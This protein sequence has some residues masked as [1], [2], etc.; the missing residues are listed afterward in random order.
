[1]LAPTRISLLHMPPAIPR[2][3]APSC[4]SARPMPPRPSGSRATFRRA[5]ALRTRSSC[6][7]SRADVALRCRLVDSR[8][9]GGSA[10]GDPL[11]P[12][13]ALAWCAC[14]CACLDPETACRMPSEG[15]RKARSNAGGL[16]TGAPGLSSKAS[17]G[18]PPRSARLGTFDSNRKVT[19][20]ASIYR[21]PTH[22]RANMAPNTG[23]PFAV[24]TMPSRA[25]E[26]RRTESSD[27]G[28]NSQRGHVCN[29]FASGHLTICD[30]Y[31]VTF[32][33]IRIWTKENSCQPRSTG[34][35]TLTTSPT[36]AR[37]TRATRTGQARD[38]VE[39]TLH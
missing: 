26:K 4:S 13:L 35:A 3:G 19:A 15:A 16:V 5:C 23:H 27:E 28:V 18:P 11:L 8:W 6:P 24:S 32:R 12:A 25:C 29:G 10:A 30:K 34:T 17:C 14:N 36:K 9:G 39:S 22:C 1:M 38:H 20:L 7:S 2:P 21:E 37:T 33:R 31:V